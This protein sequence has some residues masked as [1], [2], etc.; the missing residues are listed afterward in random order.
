MIDYQKIQEF[1]KNQQVFEKSNLSKKESFV[2]YDGPPFATGEPHYGHLLAGT[3]KDVI[4]RYH[5]MNGKEVIRRFGWDC[6][7]MP[8]ENKAQKF[9]KIDSFKEFAKDPQNVS[10]FNQKCYDLITNCQTSW[11]STTNDLGRWIDFK[12][13]Y[14]TMDVEYMESVWWVFKEIYKQNRISKTSKISL[15]STE[16]QSTVANSDVTYKDVTDDACYFG[17][18]VGFH[19]LIVYTTTPWTLPANTGLCVNSELEYVLVDKTYIIA[20]FALKEVFKGRDL[21]VEDFDI[22]SIIGKTYKSWL[23]TG[24]IVNDSY[25]KESGTGIVHLAPAYGE[26]DF[27]I[28]QV[29]NL[30]TLDYLNDS[31]INIDYPFGVLCCNKHFSQINT[32]IVKAFTVKCDTYFEPLKVTHSV[33]FY[34]RTD[35]RLIFKLNAAWQMKVTDLKDKLIANNEKINWVPET[36]GSNRFKNWLEESRDWNISRNRLWGTPLP[37][38]VAEDG[39][40]ICVGSLQELESLTGVKCK[41]IHKQFVDPLVI[42]KDGKTFKRTPEVLDCWFESGCMPYASQHYPFSKTLAYPADFIAEGLD[43]TRGWFYSLLVI[44]TA[45]FDTIPF[46]NVIV[47]GLILAEDGQ[48][49]SKSKNNYPEV[50]TILNKYGADS[51][52]GYLISS[53]AVNAIP[54]KFAEDVV[55][56]CNKNFLLPLL[57]SLN[58]YKLANE[59]KTYSEE[60]ILDK[61]ILSELDNLVKSQRSHYDSYQLQPLVLELQNFIEVLNNFYIRNSRKNLYSNVFSHTV[62]RECIMTVAKLMAPIFPFHAEHI[63][64]ELGFQE[65]IHL[66]TYP[67]IKNLSKFPFDMEKV[68]HLTTAVNSY[69]ATNAISLKT[70]IQEILI[71]DSMFG[72]QNQDLVHNLIKKVC[73]IENLLVLTKSGSDLMYKVTYNAL[74]K[75]IGKEYLKDTPQVAQVIKD[76]VY[77]N[78]PMF[79]GVPVK[80]ECYSLNSVPVDPAYTYI[81]SEEILIRS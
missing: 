76:T 70:P 37:I 2:F 12:N 18:K 23:T 41:D 30:E 52:R 78:I 79:N 4:C 35:T 75:V 33:A 65:S 47:N 17:F 3:I 60:T 71:K 49:M 39:E 34:D 19:E 50:S 81:S 59:T 5:S 27:R 1:W 61:Y 15:Y 46:K 36:I 80:Q 38:W 53:I 77:P 54:L 40:E 43:Q 13:C 28:G 63:W 42:I 10:D 7:G 6:H 45:L 32:D 21:L 11:E 74:F 66:E 14:Q 26:D 31:G 67:L 68:K 24:T 22:T 72:E 9:F 51:V 48:K 16:A 55:G 64:M 69:R 44:S 20:K 58:F 56:Q 8:I 73:N 62:L 57:S 25:V 29:H